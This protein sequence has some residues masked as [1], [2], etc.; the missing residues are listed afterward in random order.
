MLL[1][2]A[3]AIAISSGHAAMTVFAAILCVAACK[4]AGGF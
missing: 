4:K 3:R 2:P 1:L